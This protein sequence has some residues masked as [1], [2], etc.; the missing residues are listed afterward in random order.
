VA[1]AGGGDVR[2]R[3]DVAAHAEDAV[4]GDERRL[5]RRNAGQ[6]PFERGEVAVPEEA[7]LR[8]LTLARQR[9]AVDEA[10]VDLAVGDHDFVL[11]REPRDRAQT[12]L[13]AGGEDEGRLLAEEARDLRFEFYV[14]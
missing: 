7:D 13:I 1:P 5:L 8:A 3:S 11:A 10:G 14:Q 2:E 9:Q 12:G 4:H 6:P